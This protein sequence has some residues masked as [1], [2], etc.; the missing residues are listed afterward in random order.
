[1]LTD[2]SRCV[3]VRVV[4][5]GVAMWPALSHTSFYRVLRSSDPLVEEKERYHKLFTVLSPDDHSKFRSK[6]TLTPE[7]KHALTEILERHIAVQVSERAG[8]ALHQ[9]IASSLTL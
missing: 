8:D 3:R 5:A 9:T 1:M 6:I 7:E 4:W 2:F